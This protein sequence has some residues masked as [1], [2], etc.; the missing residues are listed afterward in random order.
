MFFHCF[1][2]D[3]SQGAARSWRLWFVL[4]PGDNPVTIAHFLPVEF[5][6]KLGVCKNKIGLIMSLPMIRCVGAVL[7]LL[8]PL[9]SAAQQ[10]ARLEPTVAAVTAGVDT[11]DKVRSIYGNCAETNVQ[12]LRSLC[13]YVEQDRAYLSVSSFEHESRIRSIALTT[14]PD[15]APGCQGARIAGRHLTAL[16]GISLGDSTAKVSGV[17]GAP[18]GSGK[19]Q[20]ANH[21]LVYTDYR[22]VGGQLTCQYEEEKLVL[23]AVEASPGQHPNREQASLVAFAESTAVRAVN[24]RQGDAAGFARSSNDFTESGWKDFMNVMRGFL[25]EKGAPTFTS[26]FAASGSAR[27]LDEKDGIVRIR[28]PGTLTQS[29]KLGKTTYGRAAIE[30]L[31]GGHPL[32]L[33]KVEQI[34]CLGASTACQ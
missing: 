30:V 21:Q 29:N 6:A 11:L 27:V 14:F 34:T 4:F 33:Q 12:D 32:K 5:N 18:S 16:A 13:Y 23:I 15:V 31:A 24:F 26:T 25:D 9:S 7:L 3:A 8:S 2:V 17:L 1:G 28:I 10:R 19:M 22:V 20:M